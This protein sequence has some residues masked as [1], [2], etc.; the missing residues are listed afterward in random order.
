MKPRLLPLVALLG[1]C[2]IGGPSAG[3]AATS[4]QVDRE[5]SRLVFVPTVAGGEFE[6]R[7]KSFDAAISFDPADLP[8]SRFIVELDLATAE[9]GDAE[10]DAAL[11]GADFFAV[12]RW[13]SARFTATQFKARGGPRFE[14]LGEL[15]VRDVTRKVRVPF[16]FVPGPGAGAARL[17][18]G[19][20]IA[21]LDFGVGQGDW[22]DTEWVANEVRI[23]FDLVLHRT[24]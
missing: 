24:R 22:R 17:H 3:L 21:R 18:G 2:A 19:T 6:G 4:W 1:C 12:N 11:L 8:G 13:P 16:E 14:A 20:T 23:S 15:R 9:T 10:R 5:R 7:F